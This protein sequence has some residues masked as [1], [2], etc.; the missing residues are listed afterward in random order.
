METT[1]RP[2]TPSEHPAATPD[3]IA[4]AHAKVLSPTPD[5]AEAMRRG[6]EPKDINLRGV[7]IFL[8]GLVVSLAVVLVAIY[9]IMMALVEY[10]R[11]NDP[12]GSSVTLNRPEVYA[13]L[14]P[15]VNHPNEDWADMDLM[16]R[17]TQATL[18]SSGTKPSGRRYIPIADA[19]VKVVPLLV[20][21]PTSAVTQTTEQPVP[22]GSHEGD[23]GGLAEERQAD[24][25]KG[26]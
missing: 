4:S 13:P 19:M 16:R 1:E 7:F 2:P 8:G 21:K 12:R 3:A 22:A 5:L 14:Q 23:Y 10:D 6:Y 20:V 17:D 24:R 15:S 11:S 25:A 9:G 18:D 26:E